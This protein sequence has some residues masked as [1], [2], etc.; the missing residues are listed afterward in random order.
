MFIEG[1]SIYTTYAIVDPVTRLFVYVGQTVD[2]DRRRAEHLKR[3]R[4]RKTRHPRGS[5]KA[6]LAQAEKNGVVPAFIIL[7]LVETEEQSLLSESNW[8]EK[9]AAI[10]HPLLNRW[11]EHQELIE[12]GRGQDQGALITEYHA[13]WPGRWN[14]SIAV[15]K[16][17]AKGTG[18][19]LTFPE[20][21]HVKEG[22][23]IVIMPTS[24][25]P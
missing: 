11:E 25:E 16:P 14:R 4:T 15:M 19:S 2:F 5:I 21:T 17:S 1:F 6:W 23:R 8:V 10:G 20:E 24:C 3:A 7:E 22:G 12:A 9:L 13:F 18:F